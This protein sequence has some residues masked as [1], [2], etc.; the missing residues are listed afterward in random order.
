MPETSTTRNL[1]YTSIHDHLLNNKTCIYLTIDHT[2]EKSMLDTE[3]L[4]TTSA[5]ILH[6]DQKI[7]TNN[8][9]QHLLIEPSNDSILPIDNNRQKL[10]RI[11]SR[12]NQYSSAQ[13]TSDACQDIMK[14]AIKS[15]TIHSKQDIERNFVTF[16]GK[17]K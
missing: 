3:H 16:S 17:K 11:P 15:S 10:A 2:S 12:A 4:S 9:D 8:D 5:N 13:T 1:Q 6:H 7:V 14:N